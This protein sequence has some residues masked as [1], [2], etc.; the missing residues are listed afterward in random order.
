MELKLPIKKLEQTLKKTKVILT[1][2]DRVNYLI[3]MIRCIYADHLTQRINQ[4]RVVN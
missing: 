4:I 3:G 1:K 2:P